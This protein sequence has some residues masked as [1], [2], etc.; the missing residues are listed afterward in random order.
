MFCSCGSQS[1][2]SLLNLSVI[3]NIVL[4]TAGGTGDGITGAISSGIAGGTGIVGGIYGATGSGIHCRTVGTFGG[5]IVGG[6]AGAIRIH[7]GR[8]TVNVY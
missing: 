6:I 1:L 3:L 2:V 7:C 8:S 5:R 4:G